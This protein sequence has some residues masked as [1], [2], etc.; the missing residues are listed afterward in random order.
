MICR[1]AGVVLLGRS[2]ALAQRD[3]AS[4]YSL[5]RRKA[6]QKV[7]QAFLVRIGADEEGVVVTATKFD[8]L[9]GF[10]RSGEEALGVT[11]GE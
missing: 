11:H 3:L 2:L 7:L 5:R 1:L 8:E 10:L 6:I 4:L 9:F